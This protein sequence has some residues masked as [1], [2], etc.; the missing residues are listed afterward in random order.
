MGK[1]PVG[2]EQ[3]PEKLVIFYKYRYY[4][5]AIWKKATVFVN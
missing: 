4:N 1:A 3:V 2:G 5:D